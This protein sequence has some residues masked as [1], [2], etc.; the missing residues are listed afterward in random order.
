MRVPTLLSALVLV[1]CVSPAL[2]AGP[3]GGL[4]VTV[5]N[6]P[7]VTVTNTPDVNVVNE[8][9]V[10]STD[11]PALQP[12]SFGA[13]LGTGPFPNAG[14]FQLNGPE[15]TAP[16]GKRLVIEFVNA[17]FATDTGALTSAYLYVRTT[18]AGFRAIGGMSESVACTSTASCIAISKLV[19]IY[20]NPG[21]KVALRGV[22]AVNKATSFPLFMNHG[23]S[24]YLVDLP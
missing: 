11:H 18:S 20:A 1:C 5:V 8:I 3:A 24:G 10:R 16:D 12:V 19:R 13:G 2:A 15:Y 14:V 7:A 22:L 17:E 4:D 6:T 9:A 21:D 23:F